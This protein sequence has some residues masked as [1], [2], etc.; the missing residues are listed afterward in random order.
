MLN[1]L[2]TT[3]YNVPVPRYTSYPPATFFHEGFQ[4]GDLVTA[5]GESNGL[6]PSNLSFYFHIPFC[7]HHCTYCGCNAYPM[8]NEAGVAAYMAA[9]RQELALVLP[10]LDHQRKIS[11]IHFGGGSP[12][13]I[14][15]TY[16]QELISLLLAE[17][18]LSEKPEIAIECHPGYLSMSDWEKLADAGFNRCSIGL[19]DFDLQVLK[20]VNRRPSLE[21]IEEVVAFLHARNISVNL[22]FIYGLPYQTPESFGESI[23]RAVALKPDRLV[24]F[25]YAHVPW[26]H[27]IQK[28]LEKHGLPESG[29]KNKLYE[30]ACS[31]LAENGYLRIGMDHFVLPGD[32]L[33]LASQNGQLHRNFQGYC[34]WETTGQ[35]YAFGVTGISQ[36]TSVYAQNTKSIPDYIQL[37]SDG[38]LP[39]SKGYQLSREE[40]L[41]RELIATLMCNG[42]L[43]WKLLA[44]RLGFDSVSSLKNGLTYNVS[45]LEEMA[46]DGLIL[47]TEDSIQITESGRRFIRN[48]ATVF[49]PLYKVGSTGYSLPV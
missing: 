9:V 27:H 7:R 2:L 19:Q 38:F 1:D 30:T 41:V 8:E 35:V 10:M 3:K 46:V 15:V 44:E 45:K 49:D 32:E 17:F 12:T 16:I 48:V 43:H 34:T 11:Q 29:L 42:E 31:I 47:L 4:A 22:D 6:L 20:A 28:A 23:Q 33:D 14:P 39:V 25:S 24:T 37:V 40:Q 13:S 18:S 21:P 5:I 36:L 26:V